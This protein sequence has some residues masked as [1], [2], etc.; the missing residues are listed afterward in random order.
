[1]SIET[2]ASVKSIGYLY[3]VIIMNKNGIYSLNHEISSYSTKWKAL[4]LK[5]GNKLRATLDMKL[6]VKLGLKKYRLI[7]KWKIKNYREA[8]QY[9]SPI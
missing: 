4:E 9:A 1:M 7:L 6:V 2:Q 5:L 8:I 3:G